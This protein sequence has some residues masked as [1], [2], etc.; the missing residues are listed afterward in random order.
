[1]EFMVTITFRPQDQEKILPLVPQER[2]H[3]QTL[4]E[5]GTVQALYL[6][7]DGS[8]VWIVMR[9]ES[10]EQVQKELEAFPLYPY[11]EA[12]IAPLRG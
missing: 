6:G 10:Q 2:A 11:M 5:Q 3:I 7:S 1:M 8:H 12:T 4:R 9:G